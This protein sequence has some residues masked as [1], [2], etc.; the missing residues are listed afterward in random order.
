MDTASEEPDT[1]NGTQNNSPNTVKSGTVHDPK[2][3]HLFWF[4]IVQK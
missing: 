1:S 2:V 4:I 3:S